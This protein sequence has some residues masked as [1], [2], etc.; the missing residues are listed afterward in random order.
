MSKALSFFDVSAIVRAI[1]VEVMGAEL[2]VSPVPV[3]VGAV[4]IR[5]SASLPCVNSHKPIWQQGRVWLIEPD[6]TKEAV[7][8]TAYLAVKQFVEH[9]TAEGFMYR[10]VRVFDPHKELLK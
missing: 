1:H 8:K 9:E 7:I 4:G 6:A 5:V 2:D 10:G 3:S